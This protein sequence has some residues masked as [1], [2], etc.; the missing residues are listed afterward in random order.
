MMIQ[1]VIKKELILL[2]ADELNYELCRQMNQADKE[3]G[4]LA[5]RWVPF[6]YFAS[7]DQA[8]NRICDMKVRASDARTLAELKAVIE[9]VRDEVCRVWNTGGVVDA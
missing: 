9:A 5:P 6:K 7:L 1:F 3:T 4:E 8:I 2:R